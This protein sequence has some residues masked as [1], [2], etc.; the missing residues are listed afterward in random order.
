MSRNLLYPLPLSR[1]SCGISC[2]APERPPKNLL[3]NWFGGRGA[4]LQYVAKFGAR[5]TLHI[6][7]WIVGWDLAVL[8]VLSVL[9]TPTTRI[10]TT[11]CT[12]HQLADAVIAA[13][14]KHGCLRAIAVFMVT[15]IADYCRKFI[16]LL[17]PTYTLWFQ[18]CFGFIAHPFHLEITRSL[19]TSLNGCSTLQSCNHLLHQF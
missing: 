16:L 6:D 10:T 5:M 3:E 15:Q 7:A 4:R 17:G 13:M 18:V 11:S 2:Q 9:S 1:R 14:S 8:F 19:M 12:I